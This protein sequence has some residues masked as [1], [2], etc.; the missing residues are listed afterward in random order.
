[1]HFLDFLYRHFLPVHL[2]TALRW[3]ACLACDIRRHKCQQLF[4]IVVGLLALFVCTCV[5][6]V[7]W[8]LLLTCCCSCRCICCYCCCGKCDGG[9]GCQQW[10]MPTMWP[11]C[12]GHF[13]APRLCLREPLK[14]CKIPPS[15]QLS[16]LSTHTHTHTHIAYT[17]RGN[18]N[19]SRYSARF[20]KPLGNR[21]T[22]IHINAIAQLSTTCLVL[23]WGIPE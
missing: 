13:V 15:T 8:L 6:G 23:E 10:L 2:L 4:V 1:M 17:P 11:S 19:Y 20:V 18:C 5:V 7:A 14:L 21:S 9:F 22:S 12:R 3:G 16:V